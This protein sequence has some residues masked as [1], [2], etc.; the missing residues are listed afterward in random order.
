MGIRGLPAAHGGF[1]TFA[2]HFAQHMVGRGWKVTVYCQHDAKDPAAPP[3]R[4][5][6]EW[7]GVQRIHFRVGGDGPL[8]TIGFDLKCIR[9]VLKRPGID[10]VLGYNTAVFTVLQRLYG[11]RICMNMDGIEWKR[12]KW[13]AFAKTWFWLNELAGAHLCQIPI[14]DHPEIARHLERH[15]TRNIATIPYGSS[16]VACADAALLSPY[17]LAPDGYLVSIARVEPENATLEITRRFSGAT[18]G[19]K[20]VVLGNFRTENAYHRAVRECASGEVVF[21][22]AIYQPDI[23]RALRF[24]ARAYVHGH[25]VGGTNPSLVEALGAGN[26]IL[27]HDN[28]FNRWVA[29]ENQFYFNDGSSFEAALATILTDDDAVAKAR[30]AARKQHARNFTLEKV[31]G[32]YE[33]ILDRL[34]GDGKPMTRS[35]GHVSSQ[36]GIEFRKRTTFRLNRLAQTGKPK[37]THSTLD[38]ENGRRSCHAFCR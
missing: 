11:R 14:A 30:D 33:A 29:G 1:E 13:G 24:H 34:Y 12:Q 25:T 22:G 19:M 7:Q 17:G 38:I 9:D 31:H 4:H 23:V 16:P 35:D 6:D 15:F 2:H 10:L 36:A 37:G 5:E 20:L 28:R 3:D 27:A 32:Q 8:S 18:R 21:P 26:A